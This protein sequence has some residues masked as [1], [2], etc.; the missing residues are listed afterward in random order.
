[1]IA[2]VVVCENTGSEESVL[3][4]SEGKVAVLASTGVGITV[5]AVWSEIDGSLIESTSTSLTPTRAGS[6]IS[7]SCDV[8]S[9]SSCSNND[10]LSF[11]PSKASLAS[12]AGHATSS[13]CWILSGSTLSGTSTSGSGSPSVSSGNS[14]I[15]GN[16]GISV[17]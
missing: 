1:M 4:G 13:I 3:G 6:A 8:S 15:A 11:T 16:P 17:V 12:Y 10:E 5:E 7:M 9:P 14:L 2:G